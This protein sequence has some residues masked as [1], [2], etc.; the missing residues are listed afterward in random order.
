MYVRCMVDADVLE[1]LAATPPGPQ[2]S[3]ALAAIDLARVPGGRIVHV[4]RAQSR[5]SAHDQARLWAALVE[6]G[7]AVPVGVGT[8]PDVS[9]AT[10]VAE[11]AS[12]EIAAALT[13]AQ[14]TAECELHRA[15]VVVRA[16][17][18]VFAALWS[19]LIDRAK[20]VVFAEYLDPA[21]GVT[22][23]QAAAVCARVL[24]VAPRLTTGQLRARLRRALLAIDPQWARRRYVRAV[25]GR[26]VTAVL[27]DDGTVTLTGSGLPAGE[28]A[29]A[30]AR[31]DRLAEVVKRAGHPGRLGQIAADVYLGLLDGRFHGLSEDQIAGALLR[32]PRP[33]DARPDDT[34]ADDTSVRAASTTSAGRPAAATA[35]AAT[36]P[37]GPGS[38]RPPVEDSQSAATEG[39]ATEADAAAGYSVAPRAGIEIRVG[40]T[41]AM[42]LDERPGEI[43]GLGP[44]SADVARAVVARQRRASEWR[45]AVADRDG[46]LLLAGVTR[47]RPRTPDAQEQGASGGVVELQVSGVQLAQ[48][49]AG[50]GAVRAS[51][52]M[53]EWTDVVA[54]I[55]AQFARRHD[56]LAALDAR[57]SDR[58]PHAALARHVQVRD[59]TCSHPGC[60]RPARRSELDHTRDHAAGGVTVG[61]NLGPS[62]RR[63]HR[64]KHDLGWTLAQP[65][66]GVFVWTSPL[67]QVYRTRGEPITTPL[68]DPRPRPPDPEGPDTGWAR[69]DEPILHPPDQPSPTQARPPPEPVSP[70]E[71]PPS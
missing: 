35:P 3:A 60:R 55:A 9:R 1:S 15:A 7:T 44:V 48:L 12:G 71:Q 47:R 33:E 11:W 8:A 2:L 4:L 68:P 52:K 36:A 5:Q 42:G 19:G 61:T 54:D 64:F 31:V 28:A 32:E 34:V 62:C 51:V 49:A 29:A 26:M 69:A 20:A 53:W 70:D 24:P 57:P 38:A 14:R 40:L 56:L 58:F 41:T 37:A 65:E 21:S 39:E 43:P 6:V 45:F 17:P 22:A 25:R 30:C 18:T 10:E 66:P 46:Y 50:D 63:H 27:A 13:W 23:E 67:G 59:R 16:L